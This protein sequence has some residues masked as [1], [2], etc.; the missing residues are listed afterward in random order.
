MTSTPH[1]QEPR[2]ETNELP[3]SPRKRTLDTWSHIALDAH[4]S[5]PC[6]AFAPLAA[7]GAIPTCCQTS[8][9]LQGAREA[10]GPGHSKGGKKIHD[11]MVPS[12]Q[13]HYPIRTIHPLTAVERQVDEI[14]NLRQKA[15]EDAH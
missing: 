13:A 3:H 8:Q 4:L 10:P 5:T 12:T 11:P 7:A 15:N 6:T 9:A 2:E 1:R 14:T